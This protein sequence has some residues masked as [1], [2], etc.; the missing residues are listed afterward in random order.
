M[1]YTNAAHLGHAHQEWIKAL[2]FYKDELNILEKRLT[3]ISSRNTGAEVN[4]GAEHFQNQFIIQRNNID[5]LKHSIN[6]HA[7]AVFEDV[8]NHAGR[9]E[10]TKVTD[11]QR[12][13]S[14][15]AVLEKVINELRHEFNVYVAKWI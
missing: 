9:V 8:S 2:D 10:E 6:E 15:V 14:E 3:E 7:H 11:H 5:E 12:I 4:A 13:G 1:S